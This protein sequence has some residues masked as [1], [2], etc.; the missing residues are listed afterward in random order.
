MDMTPFAA[1][2]CT[3][4]HDGWSPALKVRFLDHLAGRGN[5]AAACA[6]VGMSREAAYRLRRRDTLFA[7]GW[8]A[9]LDQAREAS[10][11]VLADKAL[12]GI[13]EEVWYRGEL[14]GTKR[15]FDARLLLAHIARLD[16]LAE[17]QD[18]RAE[19]DAARFDEIL[20]CLAGAEVPEAIALEIDPLPLDRDSAIL[21]AAEMAAEEVDEAWTERAAA[22]GAPGDEQHAE[23]QRERREAAAA[24][25]A[26]AAQVWDGWHDKACAAVDALLGGGAAETAPGTPSGSSTSAHANAI[27]RNGGRHAYT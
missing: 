24:A 8:A 2:P 17:A 5:V 18:K 13:E 14:K 16:R 26:E 10:I 20:A 11:D 27:E 6:V 19:E 12:E 7:R 1:T 15:R 4:R 3:A 23:H 25:R 9:A 21:M 22:D